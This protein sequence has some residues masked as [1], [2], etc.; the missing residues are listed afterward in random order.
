VNLIIADR[1]LTRRTPGQAGLAAATLA[2]ALGLA[3]CAAGPGRLSDSG[4]NPVWTAPP[5][6]APRAG[7]E[8]AL[9]VAIGPWLDQRQGAPGRRLGAVGA[10]VFGLHD[11]ELTLA[12]DASAVVGDAVRDQ[13]Q[14]QGMVVAPDGAD[15]RLEGAVQA[16]TLDVGA[17]DERHVVLQATLRRSSDG[18]L[19]WSGVAEERDDRFAGVSG[20]SR[21][22]LEAYLGAGIA[23]AASR[24][25]LAVR[26]HAGPAPEPGLA[27]SAALPAAPPMAVSVPAPAIVPAVAAAGF[28]AITSVPARVKVYVDDVYQG[29]T[30]ITL[31]LPAGTSQLHFKRDGHRSLSEKVAVRRGVTVELEVALEAQ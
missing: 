13:L 15:L 31:E 4:L 26:E 10:A 7:G 5:A 21:A 24:L 8:R 1:V 11:R 20:N 29:L 3:S 18:Q 19:L 30:P 28:V 6:A 12:R 2:L 17:R 25:A 22:D 9:S 14:A 27:P 23:K 16:L